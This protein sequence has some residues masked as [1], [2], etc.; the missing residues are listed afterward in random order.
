MKLILRIFITLLVVALAI[1]SGRWVWEHYLYSPWTRDGR[2]RAEVI[3]IAP[4]VSGWVTEISIKD[5]QR[6]K[7]GE[8]L[9]VVDETRYQAA[10][11]EFKAMVANKKYAW[12]LAEHEY[13]RRKKL[14]GEDG[15]SE[16]SREAKRISAQLARTDYELAKAQLETARINLARTRIE[17]PADGTVINLGLRQGN[18]VEKGEA[19]ISLVQAG[20]FYVTGYF[21]ETKLPLIEVGQQAT[22]KLMSGGEPLSGTVASIGDA[23]ANTNT[24]KD[25]QLLPQVQ[26]TFNWVRLAQRIPV[27]IKLDPVKVERKLVAG[28]TVSVHLEVAAQ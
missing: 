5:N 13:E 1:F 10:I 25:D 11:E 21:E 23:I 9:F 2:V 16:E 26:Q 7:A 17:A 22:I 27:D 19:V 12:E 18:Y 6:V 20:S 14:N 3:T 15:F 28:M 24:T 8:T 4:D